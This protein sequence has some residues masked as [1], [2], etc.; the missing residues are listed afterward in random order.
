MTK[1]TP[2]S[3]PPLTQR[4]RTGPSKLWALTNNKNRWT[5]TLHQGNRTGG[6]DTRFRAH[7]R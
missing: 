1:E 3:P 6:S 4:L 7:N 5:L 2:V